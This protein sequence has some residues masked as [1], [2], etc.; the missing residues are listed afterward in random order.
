MS[1]SSTIQNRLFHVFYSIAIDYSIN[2]NSISQHKLYLENI[3]YPAF[4]YKPVAICVMALN[5]LH[6]VQ[7]FVK[8]RLFVKFIPKCPFAARGLYVELLPPQ[9]IKGQLFTSQIT[10]RAT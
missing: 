9:P 1:R 5:C 8:F 2:Q 6:D 3:S 4:L 10:I 7:S